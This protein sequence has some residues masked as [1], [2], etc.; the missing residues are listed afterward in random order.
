M[1]EIKTEKDYKAGYKGILAYVYHQVL[2]M[3]YLGEN[4]SSPNLK[5]TWETSEYAYRAILA[6][7]VRHLGEN[8]GNIRRWYLCNLEGDWDDYEE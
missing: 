2:N 4:E 5:K 8:M 6:Y 3:E 7:A 1:E